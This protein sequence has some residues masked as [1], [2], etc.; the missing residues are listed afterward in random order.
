[1]LGQRTISLASLIAAVTIA[2]FLGM[3]GC[4]EDTRF[5]VYDGDRHEDRAWRDRDFREY[6][7]GDRHDDHR[8]E[9]RDDHHDEH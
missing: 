6:R 3:A 2:G 7:D 4:A 9:H 8:D 5:R 1:M